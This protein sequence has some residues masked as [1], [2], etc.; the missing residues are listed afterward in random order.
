MP[1]KQDQSFSG[2]LGWSDYLGLCGGLVHRLSS[3]RL[4][5][6]GL[7]NSSGRPDISRKDGI[8]NVKKAGGRILRLCDFPIKVFDAAFWLFDYVFL[9]L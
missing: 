7:D 5:D 6:L 9:Y 1:S 3:G 4:E 8:K 2:G